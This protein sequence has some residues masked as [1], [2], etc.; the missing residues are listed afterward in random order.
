MFRGLIAMA[1]PEKIPV[2][3]VLQLVDQFS[4]E[5][6]ELFQ[7]EM[8]VKELRQEIMIG[9]EQA[10]RGELIP[11]EEVLRELRERARLRMT[12]K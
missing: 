1:L 12:Q 8:K 11:A 7:C 9:V 6:F 4:P 10:N 3:Q 5:E 2:E